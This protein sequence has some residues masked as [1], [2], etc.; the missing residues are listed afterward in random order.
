M[1]APFRALQWLTNLLELCASLVMPTWKERWFCPS[2]PSQRPE[3]HSDWTGLGHR[4]SPEL[5]TVAK[6]Q[7]TL[8]E[9]ISLELHESSDEIL[10]TD[11]RRKWTVDAGK[12][13]KNVHYGTQVCIFSFF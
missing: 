12:A 3:S 2:I 7:S 8:M 13:L 6:G 1:L 5:I 9:S 11:G 4:P 10:G